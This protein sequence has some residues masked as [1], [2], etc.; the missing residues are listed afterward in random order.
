MALLAERF[1]VSFTF[2]T[3]G[4]N[5]DTTTADKTRNTHMSKGKAKLKLSLCF[6]KYRAMKAYWES[7]GMRPHIVN[8]LTT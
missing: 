2:L 5:I 8:L 7:G 4:N 1:T 6:T 3:R